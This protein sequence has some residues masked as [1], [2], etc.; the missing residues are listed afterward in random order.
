M[1]AAAGPLVDQAD[2]DAYV[3]AASQA[4]MGKCEVRT[5]QEVCRLVSILQHKPGYSML[6]SEVHADHF[7]HD[8]MGRVVQFFRCTHFFSVE[9]AATKE[10]VCL[11]NPAAVARLMREQPMLSVLTI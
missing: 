1:S 4:R 5:R 2:F 3:A 10:R 11:R 6:V 9:G 8:P 7:V